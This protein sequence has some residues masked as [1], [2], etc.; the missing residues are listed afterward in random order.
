MRTYKNFIFHFLKINKLIRYFTNIRNNK[1]P[2]KPFI[3]R[4]SGFLN[5]EWYN[6]VLLTR[7]EL[8]D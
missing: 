8:N 7:V 5:T 3:S 2:E 1:N 4:I 6:P